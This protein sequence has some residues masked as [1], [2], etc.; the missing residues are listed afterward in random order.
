[1]VFNHFNDE[2]LR[3]LENLAVLY[4]SWKSYHHR[5]KTA[6]YRLGWKTIHRHEY[7]YQ[8]RGHA[9]LGTSLGRRTVDT[10]SL[11]AEH[12]ARRASLEVELAALSP[13]VATQFQLYRALHLP[14]LSKQAG[15]VLRAADEAELLGTAL[16]VVGT[17]TMAAYELEAQSRFATGL[18]ATEDCDLTWA[19]ENSTALAIKDPKPI[20]HMLKQVDDTYTVNTERPFQARNAAAY[21][22]EILAAPSSFLGYPQKETIRPV[23]MMEQEWLLN[24]KHVEQIMFDRGGKPVKIVAPDPRW[25]A[26]HKLWLADKATRN[27]RKVDKDRRQGLA[28]LQAITESMPH[29]PLDQAFLDA[30]PAE[31]EGYKKYVVELQV[32]PQSNVPETSRFKSKGASRG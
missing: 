24:G 30:L 26:V 3:V 15:A 28:L 5:A 2:S 7:L 18:D 11:L 19:A 22:V 13:R 1:M 21:E 32:K 4:D 27:P 12:Q 10:E 20:L 16:L 29:Y 9:G 25:M 23:P 6:S 14:M 8:Q 17:N 31:L